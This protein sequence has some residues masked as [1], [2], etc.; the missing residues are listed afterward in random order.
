M[1]TKTTPAAVRLVG[2]LTD[3]N[4]PTDMIA[5]AANGY[6]GDF[7]SQLATPIWQLVADAREAGLDVIAKQAMNGDF[8]G[9]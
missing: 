7:T 8:D 4:A 2:A 6:Y 3:A 1:T 9:R 5:K